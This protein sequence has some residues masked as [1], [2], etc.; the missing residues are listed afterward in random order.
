MKL[1]KLL[2]LFAALAGSPVASAETLKMPS[3]SDNSHAFYHALLS[4]ALAA[5]NKPVEIEKR[6]DLALPRL[7]AMLE[8][9]DLDVGWFFPSTER[10]QKYVR[11]DVPL[12]NGLIAQRV[13]L[14]RAADQ[15]KFAAVT[16]VADLKA[17]SFVAGFGQGWFDVA[18]WRANRLAVYEYGG[19]WRALYKM[20]AA[21][22]R[23]VDY[24]SRGVTE[25]LPEA[26]A[27]PD[28]VIEKNLL[29]SY[30]RDYRFYLAPKNKDYAEPLGS[31]LKLLLQNGRHAALMKAHFDET[32]QVLGV[33]GRRKITLAT[34]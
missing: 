28:L 20:V 6:A 7:R 18:V 33:A 9:G 11:V 1:L 3:F 17:T 12:T 30:E 26:A 4:E 8:N 24:L 34:P 19:D 2:V 25:I 15:A 10:D 13:F 21:D 5:G 27:N 22:V 32:L 23:N 14:I 16:S 31:G 29:F